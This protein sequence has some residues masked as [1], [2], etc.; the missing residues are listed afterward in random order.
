MG[1]SENCFLTAEAN[2]F[3]LKIQ[4]EIYRC[5]EMVFHIFR[6]SV[7]LQRTKAHYPEVFSE[8][9]SYSIA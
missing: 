5:G 7:K 3:D 1:R 4:R 6:Q 2:Y 8:G 9:N